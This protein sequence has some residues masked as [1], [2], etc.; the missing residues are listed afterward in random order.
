MADRNS[1]FVVSSLK[2]ES[3]GGDKGMTYQLTVNS[4][5]PTRTV[6]VDEAGMPVEESV[7][8]AYSKYFVGLDGCIKDVP[9]RTG[10][11]FSSEPEAERY[12]QVVTKEI[13]RAG[14][15]P[16]DACPYGGAYMHV[17]G[18]PSLVKIPKGETPCM[19]NGQVIRDPESGQIRTGGCLHMQKVIEE[20]LARAKK[21]HDD[22]QAKASHWKSEDVE[23]MMQKTAEAFGAAMAKNANAQLAGAKSNLKAGKGER[24]P[25]EPA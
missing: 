17:T 18:L 8:A 14:Q 19:G 1:P 5:N 22:I 6:G 16:L 12:E 21:K 24:D 4:T 15:L 2:P 10:A 3:L 23:Q 11:G 9:M 25:G 7:P 20:R 13:V